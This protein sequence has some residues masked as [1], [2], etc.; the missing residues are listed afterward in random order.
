MVVLLLFL[1]T[2]TL[3]QTVFNTT[4]T[5][6]VDFSWLTLHLQQ[7][8]QKFEKKFAP[9][10]FLKRSET[11]ADFAA[12][13]FGRRGCVIFRTETHINNLK[14]KI[15]SSQLFIAKWCSPVNLQEKYRFPC[16]NNLNNS[17]SYLIARRTFHWP[18]K[19]KQFWLSRGRKSL[20]YSYNLEASKVPFKG[21]KGH[22][23]EWLLNISIRE[24]GVTFLEEHNYTVNYLYLRGEAVN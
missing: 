22:M 8:A 14:V 13:E 5:I 9:L 4:S 10:N 12:I 6:V 7:N 24:G 11:D 2:V 15:N 16:V 1:W 17:L 21:F 18:N 3:R 19:T 20:A 23:A